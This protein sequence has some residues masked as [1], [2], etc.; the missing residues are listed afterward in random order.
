MI[1]NTQ[2]LMTSVIFEIMG[3]ELAYDQMRMNQ[4]HMDLSLF[5]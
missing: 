5:M 2:F 4:E 1:V 3:F